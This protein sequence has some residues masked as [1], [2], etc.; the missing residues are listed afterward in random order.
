MEK[1]DSMSKVKIQALLENRTEKEQHRVETFG[2]QTGNHVVYQDNGIQTSIT[3]EENQIS[4][5]RVQKEAIL[6]CQFIAFLT[7]YGIYDIKSVNKMLNVKICTKEL[8]IQK[9]TFEITYEMMLENE[10][11][12]EFYYQLK[13]EVIP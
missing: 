2:I 1:R 6:T 12:K 13:Y 3:I 4:M 5:K 8:S 7:T 9:N 10:P 11:P